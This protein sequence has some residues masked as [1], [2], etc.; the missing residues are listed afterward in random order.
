MK[1]LQTK[2]IDLEAKIANGVN[3]V[4]EILNN[5]E[6]FGVLEVILFSAIVILGILAVRSDVVSV[7]TETAASWKT[8]VAS[9]LTQLFN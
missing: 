4:K 3:R 5:E 7:F 2:R 1:K 6:G 8:W 9:K